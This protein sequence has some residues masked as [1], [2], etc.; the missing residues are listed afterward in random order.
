MF[1]LRRLSIDGRE[2]NQFLGESYY[3]VHKDT[4][5]DEFGKLHKFHFASEEDKGCFAFVS[6][7]TSLHP[8]FVKDKSYIMTES[9]RTFAVLR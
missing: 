4:S 5:P 2:H 9:G 1:Y 3:L 7:P 6:T 8:V